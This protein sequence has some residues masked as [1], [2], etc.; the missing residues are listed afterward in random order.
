MPVTCVVGGQFGSEGKGKVA[1]EFARMRRA[2][3]AIRVG[4]ANSGHTAYDERGQAHIFRHL[5]TAALLPDVKSIIPAG[6]Y[7]NLDLL[8]AE[9]SSFGMSP[10]R[11]AIDRNAVIITERERLAEEGM[12]ERIGS[13][14][15]GT[16]AAVIARILRDGN[17]RLAGDEPALAPFIGKTRTEL[18]AMLDRGERVILEGTQGYGLSLLQSDEYPCATSRDTSAAGFVS[19]AGLSPMGDVDEIVMVIRSHPIRVAGNSGKLPNET[20]WETVRQASEAESS[21]VELSSATR[22]IRRV[23]MFD[24]AVVRAALEAHPTATLVLNHLD[25][26]DAGCADGRL[27]AKAAAFLEGVQ[28]AIGSKI[29]YLGFCPR[30]VIAGELRTQVLL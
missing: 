5:P 23:G 18:R 6:A 20:D 9:I 16:G 24:P 4:G 19:E 2:V 27:T 17:A 25:H 12:N 29:A 21:L 7:L 28:A 1:L 13:T 11:L 14:Q 22:R 3:A 30:S 10:A 8:M 15:S 26:V